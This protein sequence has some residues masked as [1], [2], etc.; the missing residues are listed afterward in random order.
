MTTSSTLLQKIVEIIPILL[1]SAPVELSIAI[2]DKEKFI[3]YFP[4]PT[5]NLHIKPGQKIDPNE[6]MHVI[7]NQN[8]TVEMDVPAE[9][10][11]IDFTTKG[12]PIVEDGRVVGGIGIG[13]RKQNERE[14]M[15]ISEQIVR[16]LSQA[17]SGL[18]SLNTDSSSLAE[19]SKHLMTQ[20]QASSE[21]MKKTDEV[22][23]FIRHVA[24]QTNLLGLNAAIEAARAGELG[25]GF[26]VVANEIRKLSQDT[27]ASA[28][29]IQ[30]ILTNIRDTTNQI[31]STI[32]KIHAIGQQQVASTKD[33]HTFMEEIEQMSKKLN[34]YAGQL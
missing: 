19:L 1:Q 17:T 16:A 12:M 20:S 25:R 29:K 6:P 10:F 30:G 3:A 13:H 28:E 11:G 15:N 14:L 26:G 5:L 8:K 32:M 31:S 21:D 24:G 2:A 18:S 33:I 23:A 4:S 34:E 27:M 22:L 9:V 7:V